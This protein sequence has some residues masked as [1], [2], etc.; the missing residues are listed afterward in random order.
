MTTRANLDDRA[1]VLQS[2]WRKQLVSSAVFAQ[3]DDLQLECVIWCYLVLCML[4]LRVC[5]FECMKQSAVKLIDIIADA[6]L[7]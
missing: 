4:A 2:T 6:N 3:A 7:I 5:Y 1:R